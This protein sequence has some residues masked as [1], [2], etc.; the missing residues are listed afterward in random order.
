MMEQSLYS[1]CA[2]LLARTGRPRAAAQLLGAVVDRL[3]DLYQ[4]QDH[5]YGDRLRTLEE[6]LRAELGVERLAVAMTAGG[7]ASLDDLR[8]LLR[9]ELRAI[10]AAA[11][12]D[13]A[14][15]LP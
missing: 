3:G 8:R 4:S 7:A 13:A 10:Q 2:E 5:L 12:P 14:P 15:T 11:T 1:Y 6:A 9:H